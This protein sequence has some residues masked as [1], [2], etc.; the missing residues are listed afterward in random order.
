MHQ[1]WAG[2]AFPPAHAN[3]Q[4]DEATHAR[5]RQNYAAMLENIDRHLGCYLSTLAARGELSNTLV[6][7][8]SDHGEMLG[9][10]ERWG[11]AT[12]HQPSVGIPMV[13]A[14]PGVARDRR[15]DGPVS[16][17]DLTAT[18]LEIAELPIP[19]DMDSRS[20]TRILADQT[21]QHRAFVCSG[22]STPP[23][24][25]WHLVF[26]GR[27]KLVRIEGHPTRLFDLREDP[28]E[29]DNIAEERPDLVIRLG[30]WLDAE[31]ARAE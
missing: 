9:D 23:H 7:Y 17:H 4:F 29:D 28:W 13:M 27:Y 8:S 6:V 25:D 31:L 21:D 18:F 30:A 11:K 10:H 2:V 3:E 16:L 1:R 5:V 22:L 24:A 14:G 19:E 15:F 26:E 12:Y 20:L